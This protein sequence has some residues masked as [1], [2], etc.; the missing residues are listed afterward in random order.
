MKFAVIKNSL[1]LDNKND[2][3]RWFFFKYAGVAS[4]GSL[5]IAGETIT[6]TENV[7]SPGEYLSSD[8][9][10]AQARIEDAKTI[11]DY[12]ALVESGEIDEDTELHDHYYSP[13]YI[14]RRF[15][16]RLP[17]EI[18]GPIE[19]LFER[20]SAD[21]QGMM[22]DGSVDGQVL[23]VSYGQ[24]EAALREIV[25]SALANARTDIE[26]LVSRGSN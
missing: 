25:D 1:F 2:P 4:D 23:A 26:N 9:S 19:T 3:P 21:L 8:P 5:R 12:I 17:E 16:R 11:S 10:D 14:G 6:I 13:N 15:A 18:I 7:S 20:A 24:F 22:D